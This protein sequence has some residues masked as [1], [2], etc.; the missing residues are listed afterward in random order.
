MSD[1]YRYWLVEGRKPT[2]GQIGRYETRHDAEGIARTF[3]SSDPIITEKVGSLPAYLL[4]SRHRFVK[5]GAG[6][7]KG[8][9]RNLAGIQYFVVPGDSPVVK[10]PDSSGFYVYDYAHGRVLEDEGRPQ[11]FSSR[12]QA[13]E[14]AHAVGAG[15]SKARTTDR[16][17]RRK[18]VR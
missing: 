7:S 18:G 6:R 1:K 13:T 8:R 4:G 17:L 2:R 14:L 9:N 3:S 10:A 16:A 15:R 12:A 5:V 11:R